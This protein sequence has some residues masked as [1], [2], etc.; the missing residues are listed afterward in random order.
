MDRQTQTHKHT[1]GNKV[2]ALTLFISHTR[3]LFTLQ[4]IF[5]EKN[6]ARPHVA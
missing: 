4:N 3:V 5:R 6:K 1:A 2:I